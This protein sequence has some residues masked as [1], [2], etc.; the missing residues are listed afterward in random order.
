[1]SNMMAALEIFDIMELL[2][3]L[4]LYDAPEGVTYWIQI[5]R[6]KKS[7][8]RDDIIMKVLSTTPGL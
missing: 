5:S 3:G 1:M 6:P 8:V 7:L 4:N 2:V